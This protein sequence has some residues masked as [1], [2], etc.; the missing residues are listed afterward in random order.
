VFTDESVIDPPRF[1][2]PESM[3][4]LPQDFNLARSGRPNWV[5]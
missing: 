3:S 5:K 4:H 1:F 2:L